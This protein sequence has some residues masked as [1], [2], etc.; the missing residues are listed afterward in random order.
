MIKNILNKLKLALIWITLLLIIGVVYFLAYFTTEPKA[1]DFMTRHILTEKLPFDQH[2]KVYGSDDIILVVIDSKS[3]EKYRWPWKRE[4]YC[5]IFKYFHEYAKPK[6]I[7][8][9]ALINAL[10]TDN[11]QSDKKY[12]DCVRKMDNYISG[13]LPMF[14]KWENQ[15]EGEEYDK[16]FKQKRIFTLL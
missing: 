16:K 8:H 3:V 13:F 10:D 6:I 7:V 2:K 14:D 4:L 11:P 1:Y 12:F 15:K 9:D 5:D